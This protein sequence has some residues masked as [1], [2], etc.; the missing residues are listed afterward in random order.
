MPRK[1]CTHPRRLIGGIETPT[2]SRTTRGLRGHVHLSWTQRSGGGTPPDRWTRQNLITSPDLGLDD[3]YV[4]DDGRQ[5]DPIRSWRRYEGG[6][7]RSVLRRTP[8]AAPSA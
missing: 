4:E 8:G 6:S 1:G 7:C 3:H 2:I 5:V